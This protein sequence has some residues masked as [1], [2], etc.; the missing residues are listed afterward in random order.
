MIELDNVRKSYEGQEVLRGITFRVNAGEFISIMG[1][2]GSGKTTLLNIIGGLD[3]DYQG[4]ALVDGRE[5]R[6]LEDKT[7]SMF[8]NQTI[9][10]IFQ[11]FHLLPHLTCAQNV[12]LPAY[13]NQALNEEQI[14]TKVKINLELVGLLHKHDELPPHLS[15]GERQRIAIAR[16]LFNSPKIILCDEPTGALDSQTGSQIIRLFENL[17]RDTGVT[18]ILV[19][20]SESVSAHA[21]RTVLIEDGYVVD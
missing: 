12:S 6:G 2:S 8:R 16:A 17:N 19:T 3:R 9:G 14:A 1:M 7:L 18:M 4:S 21:S 20:H 5:I 13:F 15:G 11:G 10:Y